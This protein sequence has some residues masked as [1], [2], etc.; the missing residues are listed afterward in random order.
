MPVIFA[1][2]DIESLT[3]EEKKFSNEIHRA[4]IA[5][6][7]LIYI[8]NYKGYIGDTTHSEIEWATQLGKKIQYLEN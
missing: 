1:H 8:I 6:A 5:D 4:K 3:P 7:D 2:A